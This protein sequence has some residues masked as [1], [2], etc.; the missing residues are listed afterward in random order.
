MKK[1][2]RGRISLSEYSRASL[3]IG[4]FEIASMLGKDFKR[5]VGNF[6]GFFIF[7]RDLF[8]SCDSLYIGL[9]CGRVCTRL[10]FVVVL[11]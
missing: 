3:Y 9:C 1:I 6:E 11:V 2:E 7:F 8:V 4:D 10:I 5:V